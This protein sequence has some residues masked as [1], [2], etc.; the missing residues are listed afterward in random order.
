ML[1][2][3][4][5]YFASYFA[6]IL[7]S[8]DTNEKIALFSLV[9]MFSKSFTSRLKIMSGAYLTT[10]MSENRSYE[11]LSLK[12]TSLAPSKNLCALLKYVSEWYGPKLLPKI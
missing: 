7:F 1:I 12:Q 9:L 4:S 5:W 8:Q 6:S 11:Y 2:I 3:A 10:E